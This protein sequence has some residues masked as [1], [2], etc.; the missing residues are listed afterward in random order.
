MKCLVASESESILG[1]RKELFTI[2]LNPSPSIVSFNPVALRKAKTLWS[3]GFSECNRVNI[4]GYVFRAN[5]YVILIF[6]SPPS[7]GQFLKEKICYP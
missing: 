2:C 6:V 7:V 3:F 1:R 5:N 4:N